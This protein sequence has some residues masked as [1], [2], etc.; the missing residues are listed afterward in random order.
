MVLAL[1]MGI[2][3]YPLIFRYKV[4]N[5]LKDIQY[6]FPTCDLDAIDNASLLA[7]IGADQTPYPLVQDIHMRAG[8]HVQFLKQRLET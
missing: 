2:P 6:P 5:L 3:V 8:E 7:Y 1:R 4:R